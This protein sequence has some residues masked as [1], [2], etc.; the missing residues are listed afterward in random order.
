[1]KALGIN[2]DN[3]SRRG[4]IVNFNEESAVFNKYGSVQA[5]FRTIES[6]GT[7]STDRTHTKG[8]YVPVIVENPVVS[9][10]DEDDLDPDKEAK[11]EYNPFDTD[12]FRRRERHATFHGWGNK[13]QK[14]QSPSQS[15]QQKDILSSF[16]RLVKMEEKPQPP[17]TVLTPAQKDVHSLQDLRVQALLKQQQQDPHTPEKPIEILPTSLPQRKPRASVS[18]I[19]KTSRNMNSPNNT[20]GSLPVV[21]TVPVRRNSNKRSNPNN[22]SNTSQPQNNDNSLSRSMEVFPREILINPEYRTLLDSATRHIRL[23]SNHKKKQETANDIPSVADSPSPKQQQ[24]VRL[25]R[26]SD[27]D[28]E[29]SDWEY[30]VAY[31]PGSLSSASSEKDF[32][33][34][35]KILIQNPQQQNP[36]NNPTLN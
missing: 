32:L 26:D 9:D 22:D 28:S 17:P 33:T 7:S 5:G 10:Y 19:D 20:I 3:G 13:T 1:L 16:K 14:P 25:S 31:S 36:Q 27:F 4:L 35:S 6:S 23:L 24:T 11:E 15:E 8:S 29:T 18:S 12:S 2:I 34:T 21:P 30:D